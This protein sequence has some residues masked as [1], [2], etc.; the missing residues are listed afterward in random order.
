M[1]DNKTELEWKNHSPFFVNLNDDLKKLKF[2]GSNKDMRQL[3][4][5]YDEL[6]DMKKHY[7][8]YLPSKELRAKLKKCN[9]IV[10][11]QEFDNLKWSSDFHHSILDIRDILEEIHEE[12]IKGLFDNGLIPRFDVI[13]TSGPAATRRS[14]R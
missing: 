7:S 10:Y 5:Y 2:I 9:L 3:R 8:I 11:A 13:D 6:N 1:G 14:K 12:I 4:V